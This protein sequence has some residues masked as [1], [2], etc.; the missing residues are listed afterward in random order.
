MVRGAG[1]LGGAAPARWKA[2]RRNEYRSFSVGLPAVPPPALMYIRPACSIPP[3]PLA[4]TVAWSYSARILMGVLVPSTTKSPPPR[5]VVKI[6]RLEES[7]TGQMGA[8]SGRNTGSWHGA[9]L[10]VR[11]VARSSVAAASSVKVL[12]A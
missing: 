10:G 8:V 9:P 2:E 12:L 4:L 3:Q 5:S 1:R 7:I 6:R 11:H